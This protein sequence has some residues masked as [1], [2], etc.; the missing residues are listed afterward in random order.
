MYIPSTQTV[1]FKHNAA[2]VVDDNHLYQQIEPHLNASISAVARTQIQLTLQRLAIA[3]MAIRTALKI[4]Y[5]PEVICS[6]SKSS[7]VAYLRVLCGL[8]HG[9]PRLTQ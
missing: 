6:F 7:S 1:A 9:R 8:A 2:I 4:P 3:V 5:L